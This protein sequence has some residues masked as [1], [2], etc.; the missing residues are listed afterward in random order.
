MRLKK[1]NFQINENFNSRIW[2]SRKKRKKNLQKKN[3]YKIYDPYL[4]SSTEKKIYDLDL[5][6]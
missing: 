4:K 6:I 2:S 3:F 5:K 1:L